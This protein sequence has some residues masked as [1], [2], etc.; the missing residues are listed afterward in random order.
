M[1]SDPL[2]TPTAAPVTL[3]SAGPSTPPASYRFR[4]LRSQARLKVARQPLLV[5]IRKATLS[6]GSV[7]VTTVVEIPS[8]AP[9]PG[10]ESPTVNVSFASPH[11]S[12]TI[13]TV[14]IFGAVSPSTQ[15]KL[16]DAVVKS[17]PAVAEPAA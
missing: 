3:I 5:A 14:I 7:I 9:P 2:T 4:V 10:P 8:A 11:P 12:S 1:T 16:P 17:F 15:I 6:K 13:A